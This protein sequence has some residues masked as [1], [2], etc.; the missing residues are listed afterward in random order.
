MTGHIVP[1]KVYY[2]IFLTLMVMTAI[3]TGV[4]FVDLGRF[5]IVVAMAIAIFK[6]SLVVLFFM[7]VHYSTKLTK[8]IV[9]AGVFWLAIMLLMTMSDLLTRGWMGVPGR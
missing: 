1:K 9:A 4:A 3:T 2:L 6:A 8:M 7:H 5:N